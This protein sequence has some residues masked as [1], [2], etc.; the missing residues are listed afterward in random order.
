MERKMILSSNLR[1][2]SDISLLARQIN[3]VIVQEHIDIS[4]VN[5]Q[6]KDIDRLGDIVNFYRETSTPA[7]TPTLLSLYKVASDIV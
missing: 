7:E 5:S 6:G 3:K 1:R 2:T 4:E